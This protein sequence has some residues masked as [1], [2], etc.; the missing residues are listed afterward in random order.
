M[1]AELA[2]IGG[3]GFSLEGLSDEVETIYVV[4]FQAKDD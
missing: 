2:V 3:V 1:N 4:E